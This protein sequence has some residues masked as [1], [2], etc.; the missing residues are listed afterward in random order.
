MRKTL[1]TL[2]TS[3]LLPFGGC[4]MTGCAWKGSY[5]IIVV[6]VPIELNVKASADVKV[7]GMNFPRL[8][9]L[10]ANPVVIDTS[11]SNNG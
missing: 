4:L 2:L 3:L 6:G 11:T 7:A 8:I 1:I 5:K 9:S 10:E